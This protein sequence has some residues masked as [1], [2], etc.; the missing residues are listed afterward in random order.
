MDESTPI[1]A[2]TIGVSV[3]I[4]LAT[5]GAIMVYYNT[6]KNSASIIGSQAQNISANYDK[7]IE[8]MLISKEKITGTDV[9][10][11][12]NHFKNDN[13]VKVNIS[14]IRF[15]KDSDAVSCSNDI[16]TASELTDLNIASNAETEKN[17]Q[18]WLKRILPNQE[19]EMTVENQDGGVRV[20]IL[21]GNYK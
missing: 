9:I 1:R 15:I 4:A 2:L 10:N 20:I 3:F 6:A 13:Y 21:K 7:T 19:F 11:I 12:L 14:G 17:F 18:T 16:C 8:D 5:V